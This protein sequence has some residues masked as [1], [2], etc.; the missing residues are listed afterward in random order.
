MEKDVGIPTTLFGGPPELGNLTLL[1]TSQ[2][3]FMN[4]FACPLFEAV[5]D[6]LPGMGFAV[7]EIKDNQTIWKRKIEEE[8]YSQQSKSEEANYVSEG[9]Q[10]PRSGS[11]DRFVFSQAEQSHPEGLPANGSSPALPTEAPMSTASPL[12][13]LDSRRSSH[14]SL[15]AL[16]ADT[17]STSRSRDLSRRSSLGH[18]CPC[19][20][21][22]QDPVSVSRRSS[23]AFPTANALPQTSTLRRSSNTIPSQLQLN[24]TGFATSVNPSERSESTRP[25]PAS[26]DTSPKSGQ[27]GASRVG[28]TVSS[29]GRR[30]SNGSSGCHRVEQVDN[31]DISP[32]YSFSPSHQHFSHPISHPHS[33]IPSSNRYSNFSS[34]ED[35]YSHSTSGAP[36]TSSHVLPSSPTDT[37]ATS[38]FTD[39]SDIG[40][41]EDGASLAPDLPPQEAFD[42][43]GL[44]FGTDGVDERDFDD[45]KSHATLASGHRI[46]RERVISRKGSRF[47]LD[48]WRRR[49]KD[50]N[51]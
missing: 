20:G 47:R 46:V 8:K 4:I 5:A 1:A 30:G 19:S 25:R 27:G 17:R 10:S 48:F 13:N 42:E 43:T 11:P 50:G 44:S 18:A 14:G 39:G 23:G 22:V 35:R 21:P 38:F 6:I 29:L 26:V 3:G 7:E 51:T 37:Q 41:G 15:S 49:A 31:A 45:V 2:I 40:I 24:I 9:F 12:P 16:L 28:I 34:S 33:I 32:G 36:T